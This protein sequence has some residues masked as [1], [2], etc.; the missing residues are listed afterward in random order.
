V[1]RVR[2]Q[3]DRNGKRVAPK[4]AHALR[5]VEL[6]PSLVKLLREHRERAFARGHAK[7]EDF[8]F[9][10]RTGGPMHYRNVARRGLDPAAEKAKLIPSGDERKAAREMGRMVAR[11]CAGTT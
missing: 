2:K 10:S 9:A 3:L 7:P 6:F 8:V 5:D 1:L 11:A 4:T